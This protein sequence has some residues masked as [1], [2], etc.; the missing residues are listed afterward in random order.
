MRISPSAAMIELLIL[1]VIAKEDAYGY[2]ISQ[3]IKPLSGAK[4]STLY[5]VLKRFQENGWVRTYDRPFQGR[6]RKYYAITPEGMK[7]FHALW[8]EWSAFRDAI[9]AIVCG[10]NLLEGGASDE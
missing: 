3:I 5:P 2:Q 7:E 1:S 6:N 9:E 4:D 10:E 8:E